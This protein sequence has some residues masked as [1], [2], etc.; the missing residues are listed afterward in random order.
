MLA[1]PCQ[2]FPEAV[3][4]RSVDYMTFDTRKIS[5]LYYVGKK[6]INVLHYQLTYTGS[7]DSIYTG[8]NNR[9][10]S[11]S[12]LNVPKSRRPPRPGQRPGWCDV[13]GPEGH[14]GDFSKCWTRVDGAGAW[15]GGVDGW[16]MEM[17]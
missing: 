10:R 9:C 12:R 15:G 16:K 4:T 8:Q 7:E 5:S 14:G 2:K 6:G 13:V 3:S 11:I 17:V 1:L